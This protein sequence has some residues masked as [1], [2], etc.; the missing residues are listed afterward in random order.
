MKYRPLAILGTSSGSGKSLIS[1]AILRIFSDK[2]I[3]VAPFKVQNMSLNAIAIPGGEIAYAQYIQSRAARVKANVCMN[4]ILLK[5]EGNKTHIILKGK[6]YG[7]KDAYYYFTDKSTEFFNEA[8]KCFYSLQDDYDLIVIE[9][10]G[11]PA[12]INLKNDIANLR[13]SDRVGAKNILVADIERGGVF[14]S[15][16][17]TFE[18]VDM[19][20]NIGV[21]IN[22]FMG[23]EKILYP[24]YE[25]LRNKYGI[26]VLG[27]VPKINHNIPE[28]DSLA[29]WHRR[30]GKINVG[31]IWM[32]NMS[33][34]TDLESLEYQSSLGFDFID[35]PQDLDWADVIIIP[36]SKMTVSD[37][38]YLKSKGFDTKL[39]EIKGKKWIIG[40]CGGFQILGKKIYDFAE[41][42]LGEVEGIGILD[43]ETVM[44]G[45]KITVSTEAVIDCPLFY[46]IKI[47]GYEIHIGKTTGKNHFSKIVMED[48]LKTERFDGAC[49]QKVIG[50]YIHGLFDN[51]NFIK[52]FFNLVANEKGVNVS[53][54]EFSIEKEIDKFSKL[55]KDHID[56]DYILSSISL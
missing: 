30:N 12:E 7:T 33:N 9:G 27:T 6:Y 18:L 42:G 39:R 14:S 23:N 51:Y 34:L 43:S 31:V 38:F 25:F 53:I 46:P 50:T 56:I 44:E 52:N 54:D 20:N 55:V 1:L 15:I 17:G 47:N 11:S 36:G 24:G 10:A 21:I 37:L 16:V 4:P 32:P 40:L 22:K 29:A 49:D 13:F 26:K 2:G 3:K 5:P 19:S 28:E 48:N 45:S 8:L 35:D 41:T